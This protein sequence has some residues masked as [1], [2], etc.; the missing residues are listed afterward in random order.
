MVDDAKYYTDEVEK[1]ILEAMNH[2]RCVSW[3]EIGLD[4]HYSRLPHDVQQEVFTRQLCHAVRLGK[5]LTIHTQEAN[6]DTERI[7]KAEVPPDFKR[8]LDHFSNLYIG[9]TGKSPHRFLSL[10]SLPPLPGIITYTTNQNT[11]AVVRRMATSSPDAP[12]RIVLETDAPFMTPANLYKSP[13]FKAAKGK[14]P[15]SHTAMIP[16]TAAYVART[17]GS[18][19][20]VECVMREARENARV[21]YGV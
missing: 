13:K 4:Y 14:L 8:L 18:G 20:T 16:W 17:A 21:L 6:T 11:S 10:T 5:T 12:L 15:L 2:P 7:L 1:D 3:G 19:W 9:I